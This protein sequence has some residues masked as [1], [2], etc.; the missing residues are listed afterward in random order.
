MSESERVSYLVKSEKERESE[1][2]RDEERESE[3]E[4]LEKYEK[5][6]RASE[7]ERERKL[8]L[9]CHR[10]LYLFWGNKYFFRPFQFRASYFFKFFYKNSSK[11][12][13]SH[14][15]YKIIMIFQPSPLKVK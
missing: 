3:L 4:T 11:K 10:S 2:Q 14:F 1:L 7:R 8:S 6:E 5:R 12:G 13:R 9:Y 15:E